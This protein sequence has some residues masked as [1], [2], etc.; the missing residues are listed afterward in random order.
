MGEWSHPKGGVSRGRVRDAKREQ[1]ARGVRLRAAFGLE[2][3]R[4]FAEVEAGQCN[5]SSASIAHRGSD[6][7]ICS[8]NWRYEKSRIVILRPGVRFIFESD[9]GH[10]DC[11]VRSLDGGWD[12]IRARKERAQE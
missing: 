2:G 3:K 10:L 11:I 4:L 5:W 6:W 9:L 12:S 7:N 8:R 1:H